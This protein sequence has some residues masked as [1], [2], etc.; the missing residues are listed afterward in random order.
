MDIPP[1]LVSAFNTA[2]ASENKIHDDATAQ[3]FGFKGGFVG[4]VNV[5][6]YMSHQPLQV[7]LGSPSRFMRG[8]W[9]KFP[10]FWMR[11][12]WR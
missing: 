12:V 8:T 2:K 10:L 6:A 4:G 5:Y 7:R 1:Y 9:L 3:R 11:I